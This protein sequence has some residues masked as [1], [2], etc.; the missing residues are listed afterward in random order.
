MNYT[1]ATEL[2]NNNSHLVGQKY[3]GGIIEDIVI[4]PKNEKELD[5][6]LKSYIR[7]MDGQLSVQPFINSELGVFI[8]CDKAKI[9]TSSLILMTEIENLLNENIDVK[10]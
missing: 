9:R 4:R 2:R 5:I 6:F 3:K 1:E 10:L 7:T 8:V